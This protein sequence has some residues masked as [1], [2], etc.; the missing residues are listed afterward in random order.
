MKE[1]QQNKKRKEGEE[2]KKKKRHGRAFEHTALS[3]TGE[4]RLIMTTTRVT[5]G[6]QIHLRQPRFPVFRGSLNR[7][8]TDV[9]VARLS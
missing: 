2:K 5:I 7:R 8:E 3:H 6:R 1:T 9:R 4:R